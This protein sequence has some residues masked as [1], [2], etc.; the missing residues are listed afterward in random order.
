MGYADNVPVCS[1]GP[2]TTTSCSDIL[3]T[4]TTD[5][6]L[7]GFYYVYGKALTTNDATSGLSFGNTEVCDAKGYGSI[8]NET[9]HLVATYDEVE[10]PANSPWYYYDR[11]SSEV[12]PTMTVFMP[13]AN[14]RRGTTMR[15]PVTAVHC[16]GIKQFIEGSRVPLAAPEPTPLASSGKG[17]GG[18]AIAGIVVGAVVGVGALVAVVWFCWLRKRKAKRKSEAIPPPPPSYPDDKPQY[19][20][21]DPLAP[22]EIDDGRALQEMDST[23]A[24]RSELPAAANKDPV[25]LAGS[26]LFEQVKAKQ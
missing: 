5:S 10:D 8:S 20:E 21:V 2:L 7:Q 12:L 17:L 24:Y 14:A 9:F 23:E 18:G 19:A 25:E 16:L 15:Y 6:A 22:A 1:V 11:F 4:R 13:V 26:T 3:E